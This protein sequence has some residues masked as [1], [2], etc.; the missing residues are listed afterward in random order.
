MSF[1]EIIQLQQQHR[2]AID[3]DPEAL[4]IIEKHLIFKILR[5]KNNSDAVKNNRKKAGALV[6]IEHP[7]LLEFSLVDESH[8]HATIDLDNLACNIA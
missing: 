7:R 5:V 4:R 2:I 1:I 3:K 8:V 6:L